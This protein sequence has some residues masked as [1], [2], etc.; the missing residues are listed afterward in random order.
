MRRFRS[1]R[2]KGRRSFS[3]R[4]RKSF[5]RGGSRPLRIGYRF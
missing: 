2:R 1:S 5:R 3:R 4:R